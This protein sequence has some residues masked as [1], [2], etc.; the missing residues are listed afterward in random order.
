MVV[1]VV[2]VMMMMRDDNDDDDDTDDGDDDDDDDDSSVGIPVISYQQILLYL[3][4]Q[5]SVKNSPIL[6]LFYF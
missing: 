2:V 1:V 4:P 6:S 5:L 3:S